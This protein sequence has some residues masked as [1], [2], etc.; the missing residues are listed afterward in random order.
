M[1]RLRRRLED[2][3]FQYDGNP[4]DER[5][6]LAYK[7]VK[8]IKGFYIHLLVYVLVNLF[9]LGRKYYDD[10]SVNFYDWDTFSTPIFWGIGIIAHAS[11]V[12]GKDLFFSDN[13]EERKIKEYMEKEKEKE[14][15]WE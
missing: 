10:G 6:Y 11:S 14:K 5:Y 13:W 9:I 8:R 15:K 4:S 3:E 7:R 1:G 12:F 2:M